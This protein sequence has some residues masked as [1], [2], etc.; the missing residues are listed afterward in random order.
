MQIQPALSSA[1]EEIAHAFDSC[2][3]STQDNRPILSF[4][5]LLEELFELVNGFLKQKTI[6][7]VF[8]VWKDHDLYVN[9]TL[10]AGVKFM[11][12]EDDLDVF[13][14]ISGLYIR[15]MTCPRR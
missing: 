14:K 4:K 3:K 7:S 12:C 2:L 6:Y 1:S 5:E 15:M 11:F 10:A 13:L 9:C 8:S